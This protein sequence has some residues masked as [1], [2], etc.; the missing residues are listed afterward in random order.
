MSHDRDTR[1]DKA[2]DGRRERGATFNFHGLDAAFLEEAPAVAEEFREAVVGEAEGEV[3]D[4]EGFG[5][6]PSDGGG[7][8]DHHVQGHA[9]GI[10]ESKDGVA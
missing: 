8:V 5:L 9:D 2:G 10:G 3:A 4:H 1:I 7:V 6:G